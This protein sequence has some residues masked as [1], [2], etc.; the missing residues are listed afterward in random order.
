MSNRADKKTYDQNA[1]I[2]LELANSEY[3]VCS[4]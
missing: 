2:F 4:K 1:H 3:F